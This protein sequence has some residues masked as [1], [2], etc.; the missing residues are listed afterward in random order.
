MTSYSGE[1]HH[2]QY[3]LPPPVT[4][5]HYN[6]STPVTRPPP[7]TQHTTCYFVLLAGPTV[8]TLP[9]VLG[10]VDTVAREVNKLP[11]A[12]FILTDTNTDLGKNYV[13]QDMS[14]PTVSSVLSYFT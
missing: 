9:S 2:P 5:S 6:Q 14:P 13:R 1:L 7:V 4:L 3:T 10:T 8:H 11:R 12:V